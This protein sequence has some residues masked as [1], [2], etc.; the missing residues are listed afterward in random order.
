VSFKSKVNVVNGSGMFVL[1]VSRGRAVEMVERKQAWY[2]DRGFIVLTNQ[3]VNTSEMDRM[4]IQR[5]RSNRAD[6]SS[7]DAGRGIT[8]GPR[9]HSCFMPV[10]TVVEALPGT[11]QRII[12]RVVA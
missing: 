4:R 5:F 11:D 1:S 12:R 6:S 2:Q 7:G 10:S 9:F 3:P 8:T